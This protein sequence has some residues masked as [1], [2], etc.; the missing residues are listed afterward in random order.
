MLTL[1]H[2]PGARSFRVLWALEELR[3]PYRLVIVPSPARYRYPDYLALNPLG[4]VPTFY[5]GDYLITESAVVGHY[6]ATKYDSSSD[7]LVAPDE[8][9]YAA[10]L[11]FLHHGESTLTF[12][13]TIFLR[14]TRLEPDE[15]LA[16]AAADYK[17]WFLARTRLVDGVL[18][19]HDYVCADRF[20]MADISIAYAFML[21]T[22]LGYFDELSPAIQAYWARL[23][24]RDA[25][26]RALE[27]QQREAARQ[28]PPG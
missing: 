20:T 25:C 13:Q 21:A 26:R 1:Y 22:S 23:Q 9:G 24:Q 28:L 8:E 15:R 3:L 5:D 7:L 4:T 2:A 18:A 27:A 11:N 10:Y 16:K 14:Y 19:H 17:R 12:P 6:L